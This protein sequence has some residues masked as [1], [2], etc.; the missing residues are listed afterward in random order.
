V[1]SDSAIRRARQ[2][3]DGADLAGD[4]PLRTR[5]DLLQVTNYL[6]R[7]ARGKAERRELLAYIRRFSQSQIVTGDDLDVASESGW[8]VM[9]ALPGPMSHFYAAGGTRLKCNHDQSLEQLVLPTG[10]Q[11]W[12]SS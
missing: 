11:Q 7:Q 1:A 12:R 2:I 4:D 3:L 6:A 5:I 9:E 10:E 8:P